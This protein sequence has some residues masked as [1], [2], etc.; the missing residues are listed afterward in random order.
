LSSSDPTP[1]ALTRWRL[2]LAYDG[3]GFRGFADQPGLDTVAGALKAQLARTLRLDTPPEITGAGRTDAGVHALHQVVHVDL[4]EPLFR[5]DRPDE[6]AER[7]RRALN[8]ALRGRIEVLRVER[9]PGEFHAR[10]SATARAYR[11]LVVTDRDP[12]GF[13]ATLAWGVEGPLDLDAM[14]RAAAALVGEHDFRAFC[15]RPVGTSPDD[16]LRREVTSASWR[17]VDDPWSLVAGGAQILRFDVAANAFCHQMVRSMVGALV[18]I[19]AGRLE[20]AEIARRL[21][22]P[23]RDRLPAPA[24]AR[25]L[26]LVRVSYGRVAEGPSGSVS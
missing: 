11:Y 5:D 17:V 16:P 4:P 14:N 21:D 26:A 8:R 7:I 20:E 10:F 3:A 25:G 1:P 24:P 15:K 18:A 22:T 23:V 9:V 13:L 12:L 19:G 2:D 6:P